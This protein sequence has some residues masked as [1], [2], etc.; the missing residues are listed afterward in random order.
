MSSPNPQSEML[1]YFIAMVER[2]NK[3]YKEKGLIPT[4]D[5][6]LEDLTKSNEKS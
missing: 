6:V 1:E 5:L 4:L 3:D 2:L